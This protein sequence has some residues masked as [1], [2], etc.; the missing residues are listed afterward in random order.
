MSRRSRLRAMSIVSFSVVV[1]TITGC[2]PETPPLDLSEKV[3]PAW[4]V[5]LDAVSSSPT[6]V[7]NTVLVYEMRGNNVFT[8]ASYSAKDGSE[9]WSHEASTGNVTQS[10][11]LAPTVVE[12][13]DGTPLIGMI[14]PPVENDDRWEHTLQLLDPGT[15]DLVAESPKL[16][17]SGRLYSC[18]GALCVG[19]WDYETESSITARLALDDGFESSKDLDARFF[20][21]I[22][23]RSLDDDLHISIAADGKPLEFIVTDGDEILSRTPAEEI[24]PDYE[25]AAMDLLGSGRLTADGD[26]IVANVSPQSRQDTEEA[27]AS[28][29]DIVTVGFE[30][31]TGEM[32]WKRDGYIFCAIAGSVFCTGEDAGYRVEEGAGNDAW[33]FETGGA[34]ELVRL[35][36]LT[37]DEEWSYKSDDLALDSSASGIHPKGTFVF[38]DAGVSTMISL[39]TG[40]TEP[41]KNG[42]FLACSEEKTF[43]APERSIPE[44]GLVLYDN[45]GVTIGCGPSGEITD[46]AEFTTGVV[47]S[48]AQAWLPRGTA[49]EDSDQFYAL[50]TKDQLV[51][52]DLSK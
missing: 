10:A 9:L 4:S 50:Q 2:T 36:P 39:D 17:A 27:F 30:R 15:G 6:V 35:D 48:G 38:N 8:L 51:G 28:V 13:A 43:L 14:T 1:L 41:L 44:R 45:A 11:Y 3:E 21:D 37:G 32:L 16:W 40:E 31:A 34:G 52:Y 42:D 24:L 26:V 25:G 20:D 47:T 12:T 7:D 23:S 19:S 29:D 46:P 22:P 49:R 33:A 18:D 5:N